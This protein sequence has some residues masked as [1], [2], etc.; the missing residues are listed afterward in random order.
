MDSATVLFL[1]EVT[2]I[3]HTAPKYR[4]P[5]RGVLEALLLP[6]RCW[7]WGLQEALYYY[8]NDRRIAEMVENSASNGGEAVV[9][10]AA[11]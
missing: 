10:T 9:D 6:V 11:T 4:D 7:T 8:S 2:L 5:P 3:A 1:M